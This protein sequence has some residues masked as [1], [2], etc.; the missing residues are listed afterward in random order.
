MSEQFEVYLFK[1]VYD[2]KNFPYVYVLPLA[3]PTNQHL[4]VLFWENTDRKT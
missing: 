4:N 2:F 1:L 3:L